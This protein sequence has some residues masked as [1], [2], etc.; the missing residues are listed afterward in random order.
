MPSSRH[1]FSVRRTCLSTRC[2]E[3]IVVP[4]NPQYK[5]R[6]ISHL[7][8]DSGATIVVALADLVPRGVDSSHTPTSSTETD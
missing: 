5:T 1:R 2:A 4:M 6:E 8:G 7:L 3:G